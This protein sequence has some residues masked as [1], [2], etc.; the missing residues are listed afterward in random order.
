MWRAKQFD[1]VLNIDEL[2]KAASGELGTAAVLA[3]RDPN[4]SEVKAAADYAFFQ[5]ATAAKLINE[6]LYFRWISEAIAE[7]RKHVTGIDFKRIG[8]YDAASQS[9]KKIFENVMA[10]VDHELNRE[11]AGLYASINSIFDNDMSSRKYP[12]E[13][14]D[15][16]KNIKL[17]AD[18]IQRST[19][20]IGHPYYYAVYDWRI[21]SGCVLAFLLAIPIW[22]FFGYH[23]ESIATLPE[24]SKVLIDNDF[25]LLQEIYESQNKSMFAKVVY[26][27]GF[28]WNLLLVVPSIF[29]IPAAILGL[30]RRRRYLQGKA[31]QRLEKLFGDI[32]TE[33]QKIGP[34]RTRNPPVRFNM[35]IAIG[36]NI[37]QNIQATV[38][39]SYNKVKGDYD[40]KT[41]AFLKGVADLVAKSGDQNAADHYKGVVDNL[42]EDRKGM[43]RTMWDGL[44]KA[45]PTV[46]ALAGAGTAIA[47]LFGPS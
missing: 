10:K 21:L 4:F 23:G 37:Q 35:A 18:N 36:S 42:K 7:I 40:S 5:P 26:F 14:L 1:D 30:A 38:I 44:V 39:G 20:R 19:W 47:K 3:V 17:I 43:A 33:L 13:T 6:E 28:A 29:L 46:G 11:T 22:Y 34:N 9:T 41:D 31:S 2:A 27:T 16:I 25:R 32:G 12:P 15:Q 24:K 45:L 8:T